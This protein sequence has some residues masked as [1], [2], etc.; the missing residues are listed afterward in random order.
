MKDPDAI[1]VSIAIY[2]NIDPTLERNRARYARL[3]LTFFAR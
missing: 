2:M 3:M 1:D